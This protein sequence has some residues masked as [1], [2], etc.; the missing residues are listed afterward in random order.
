MFGMGFPEM[1]L[2]FVIALIVFGPKRLPELGRSIGRAMVEFK[3]AQQEF[4]DSMREEMQ[5]V[6]KAA[7][8]DG[9][10]KLAKVEMEDAVYSSDQQQAAPQQLPIRDLN[11]ETGAVKKDAE[12][13]TH[14][15]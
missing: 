2:I 10:K 9:I 6:E 11:P 4:Q 8:I 12:S 14:A 3:K 15:G 5:K 7:D 13:T 1:M